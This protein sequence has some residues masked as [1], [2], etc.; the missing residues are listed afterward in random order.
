M[1]TPR[2]PETLISIR[3]IPRWLRNSRKD[4]IR[5]GT[6]SLM[7]TIAKGIREGDSLMAAVRSAS[8]RADGC[9]RALAE[10][11][12]AVGL[13]LD[14]GVGLHDALAAV[15]RRVDMPEFDLLVS[16][17]SE[18]GRDR[19][20]IMNSL[21]AVSDELLRR[22]STMGLMHS[23]ERASVLAGA[24]VG[25]VPFGAILLTNLVFPNEIQAMQN[26]IVA[27]AM[28]AIAFALV[29]VGVAWIC[30]LGRTQAGQTPDEL[31][32]ITRSMPR[33]MIAPLL[34]CITPS[35]LL[36]ALA[37]LMASAFL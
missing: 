34:L 31:S 32:L 8:S 7:L 16:S 33:R 36:V 4:Q 17:C 37:P 6:P 12:D 23:T 13:L 24:V 5:Q 20:D 29:M 25:C 26:S 10:E 18:V 19:K 2:A 21:R 14:S 22:N 27:Q 3:R 9:P 11:M 1:F 30:S 35:L 28:L 15:A